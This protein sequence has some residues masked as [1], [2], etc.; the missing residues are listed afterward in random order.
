MINLA[1]GIVLILVGIWGIST[2]WLMFLDTFRII[3]FL[4]L[5][6]FGVVAILAGARKM[7][8]AKK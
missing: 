2:H 7:G 8:Q 3:L 1:M 6:G 5:V 4:G